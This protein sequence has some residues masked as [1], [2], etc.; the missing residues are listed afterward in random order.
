MEKTHERWFVSHM[1]HYAVFIENW[2]HSTSPPKCD[3]L[4][5]K[6][7]WSQC[8][9]QYEVISSS[10]IRKNQFDFMWKTT[11]TRASNSIDELR[12]Q[13]RLATK[14]GLTVRSNSHHLL[15]KND[16][17]WFEWICVAFFR[18]FSSSGNSSIKMSFLSK[19]FKVKPHRVEQRAYVKCDCSL[20]RLDTA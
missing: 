9:S 14:C 1:P 17:W 3:V 10:N 6:H 8:V 15:F 12:Q 7:T 19:P 16:K 2:F 20:V 13:K 5:W 18:R 4:C 11:T